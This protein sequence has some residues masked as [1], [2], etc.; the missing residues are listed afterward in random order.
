MKRL[1]LL[2]LALAVPA[3]AQTAFQNY[4]Y[5]EMPKRP[6]MLTSQNVQDGG[7]DLDPNDGGPPAVI[8]GA[9]RGTFFLRATGPTLYVKGAPDAGTWSAVASGSG[10]LPLMTAPLMGAT[11]LRVETSGNDSTCSPGVAQPC[12]TVAGALAYLKRTFKSIGYSVDILIGSGNFPGFVVQGFTFEPIDYTLPLTLRIVGTMANSTL[13]TST[14]TGTFTSATIGDATTATFSIAADNTKTWT[15]NDLKGRFLSTLT[16]TSAL[17][18]APITENTATQVTITQTTSAA[19][20]VGGTFAIQ[21]PATIINTTVPIA[22]SLPA[23]NA[24]SQTPTPIQAGIAVLG[25]T[26]DVQPGTFTVAPARIRIEQLAINAASSV[27]GY[28][29][30]WISGQGSVVVN[31]CFIGGT[32]ASAGARVDVMGSA[33]RVQVTNSVIKTNAVGVAINAQGFGAQ[34]YDNN[35]IWSSG[36]G[37]IGLSVSN[38][39]P[40]TTANITFQNGKIE[41]HSFGVNITNPSLVTLSGSRIVSGGSQCIRSRLLD[42]VVGNI[43]INANSLDLS[44]ASASSALEVSGPIFIL[45]TTLKGTG[46]QYGVNLQQSAKLKVGS[47]SDIAGTTSQVLL[48]GVTTDF[49]AM[50]AANP[51]VIANTYTTAFW[52]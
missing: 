9:P 14:A 24:A 52:E 8:S 34:N 28:R 42:A 30:L 39:G 50:R 18:I 40:G 31:R 37:N 26:F 6:V 1:A 20:S 35:F 48:D 36:T 41:A 51:K 23:Y 2:L 13:A 19:G 43:F 3:A 45:V 22:S 15:V 4:V 16:G 17:Q 11:A 21:D 49:A 25:N 5:T 46:N 32:A 33:G 27:S 7:F 10:S 38:S 12:A 44:G 47:A 29:G